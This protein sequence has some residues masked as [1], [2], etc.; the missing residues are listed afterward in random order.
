MNA[1][2]G[3]RR[4]VD[5]AAVL[6]LA[7][8]ELRPALSLFMA[9]HRAGPEI[10]QDPVRLKTLLRRAEDALERHGLTA[11]DAAR[12]VAPAHALVGDGV[13][14]RH[15]EDG[16]AVFLAPSF[17][18]VHR[19]ARAFAERVTVAERF[20]VV[21]LLPLLD[22]ERRFYVLALS[23]RDVRL[24][25]ATA[26]SAVALDLG[27]LPRS[28]PEAL[29]EDVPG[30]QLQQH[31]GSAVAGKRG[32]IFHGHG[33]WLDQ[34]KDAIRQFF[35]RVDHGLRPHL[36]DR[37]AP[38]VLAAVEYLV[39]LYREANTHPGLVD[40]AIPGNPEGLS[41]D[42]LRSRGWEIVREK[43]EAARAGALER[44]REL[45]AAGRVSDELSTVLLGAAHGRVAELLVRADAEQWG[46]VE[47]ASERVT[48][49]DAP[50]PG[51]EDLVNRAAVDTLA[52]SGEVHVLDGA[53]MP[54][55]GPLAAIFRY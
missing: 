15:Q 46:T 48:V 10:R 13:F 50:A 19:A 8:L 42:A 53:R 29:L 32:A 21:Q 36:R 27:D 45:A 12:V 22:L 16:L 38:L 26:T 54:T 17:V 43:V 23:Q 44:Y 55:P 35:H 41:V 40:G 2:P 20:H 24:I 5:R 52:R 1:E 51:R 6:E 31:V 37:T 18:R 49:A 11:A 14:W 39:P 9:T 4:A 34:R 33:G 3:E 7:A 25:E 30:Q 28:V 47:P